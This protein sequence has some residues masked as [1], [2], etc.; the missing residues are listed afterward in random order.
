MMLD[1]QATDQCPQHHVQGMTTDR[2]TPQEVAHTP[3]SPV[4]NETWLCVGRQKETGQSRVPSTAI[5]PSSPATPI[6]DM[7]LKLLAAQ[8]LWT[9]FHSEFKILNSCAQIIHRACS[10]CAD[11]VHSLSDRGGPATCAASCKYGRMLAHPQLS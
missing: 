3:N 11:C 10:T 5:H 2:P 7:L 1:M 4:H 8:A 6:S 9:P